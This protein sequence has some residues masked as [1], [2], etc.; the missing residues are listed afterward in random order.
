MNLVGFKILENSILCFSN[1]CNQRIINLRVLD[2]NKK[3]RNIQHVA[4]WADGFENLVII[5]RSQLVKLYLVNY[6]FLLPVK[7]PLFDMSYGNVLFRYGN[8]L[9]CYAFF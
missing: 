9:N 1:F 8:L 6:I 2:I 3:Y 4:K 5:K 7:I